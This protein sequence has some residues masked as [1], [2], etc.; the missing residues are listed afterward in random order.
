MN[1]EVVDFK[2]KI[3]TQR[4]DSENFKIYT[5]DV[6]TSLYPIK[7]NNS[8]DFIIVGD[9][10]KLL[11]DVE[12]S[13]KAEVD[14]HKTFG[15]QYKVLSI[16]ID[17]KLDQESTKSFLKEILSENQAKTLLSVYPD[18]IERVMKDKPVDLSLLKG[19][20]EITYEKI[21]EKIIYNYALIDLVDKYGGVLS[22]SVM[23]KLYE[24][25]TSIELVEK[26][27]NDNPYNC[28]CGLGRIGFKTADKLILEMEGKN[29]IKSQ[30][31]KSSPF[32][33][34][35]AIE[36][37]L[38]ENESNGS[39]KMKIVDLRKACTELAP[40]SISY[41]LKILRKYDGQ[42]FHL[43]EKD[44]SV[45]FSKT[46]EIERK[47]GLT[48]KNALMNNINYNINIEFYRDFNGI[49]LTDEQMKC[50]ENVNKYNVSI[51]TAP[52]GSGK[53][54]T[55]SNLINMLEDNGYTYMMCTPTGKSADI[56]RM[57]TGKDVGTIHRSL[58]Y[59]P[60]EGWGYNEFN[61][62]DVDIVIVDEFSMTDIWLMKHL[63]DAIDI[64]RTKILFVFDSYQLPSVSAG[65]VA[66]DLLTSGIIP[67]TVLT[68]IFRYNEGGLMQIATQIRKSENFL[69]NNFTG[70][71][72]FGVN[73][74]F[75]YMEMQQNKIKNNI[76]MV[77]SKLIND[78]YNI[79]DIIVLSCQNKG[80]YGTKEINKTIQEFMQKDKNNPY[81]KK[82]DTKFYLKDKVMQISN[83][84]EAKT[85]YGSLTEVFNG[86]TGI[87][88]DIKGDTVVV[89]F[90]NDKL[91]IYNKD[92]LEQLELSY[93]NTYHKIQGDSGKQV[94]MIAPKAHTFMLNS[95]L[96]YVGATRARERVWCIGNII[97]IN[98]AIKKKENLSRNTF[99]L[100]I[101]K[102]LSRI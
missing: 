65:N 101:I 21:K 33:I 71:K 86:N 16:R 62:L 93:C 26:A 83:N 5:V 84:Y 6:D 48:I 12:Y 50:L 53:S 57:Y 55:V 15:K 27:M 46:Y 72:I 7:P 37:V 17:G 20:K 49:T 87:I 14:I 42:R 58:A 88:V 69:P 68:K 80:D 75:I 23:K 45:G 76:L 28:L 63:L 85:V 96:L 73:K 40:E 90:G 3:L 18:I 91:L 2:F 24:K 30:N 36:Y 78:G 100:D 54:Q 74:D 52:A 41:F 95:N 38:S 25:Y 10:P 19:I 102:D 4:Y 39:T 11:N 99:L 56:L 13:V 79:D 59:N 70:R 29:K 66:H 35:S 77:Y 34:E 98:R 81:I 1:K 43:Q 61:Q 22:F 64:K 44:K 31:L 67:T 47:I 97:T 60:R 89:D 8:G 32:R 9:I 92:S 94:I 51:L 82:G